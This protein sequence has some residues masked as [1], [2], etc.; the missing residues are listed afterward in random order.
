M[1]RAPIFA[2]IVLLGFAPMLMAPTGGYPSRPTFQTTRQTGALTLPPSTSTNQLYN[3]LN[4]TN[5]SI[6]F[7][8]SAGAANGHFFEINSGAT[9]VLMRTVNDAFAAVGN[10]FVLTHTATALTG[11]D[12]GNATDK[13]AVTVNGQ[14][15][16]RTVAAT[17]NNAAGACSISVGLGINTGACT[18]N[19]AGDYTITFATAFAVAPICTATSGDATFILR[20]SGIGTSTVSVQTRTTA[21]A[22]ADS[23]FNVMCVGN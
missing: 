23:R 19:G 13:P 7:G 8:N 10:A 2:L 6:V 12:I 14:T 20:M 18:Y 1:K 5:P 9:Q 15:L 16:L 4:G 11:I 17:Q 3:G 21:A 22:L